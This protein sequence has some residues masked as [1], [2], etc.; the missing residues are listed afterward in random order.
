VASSSVKI[1]LVEDN[2]INQKV[3]C[4]QLKRLGYTTVAIAENGEEALEMLRLSEYDIVLMDCQ[5]PILDGYSAT[6]AIRARENGTRHLPVIAMTAHAMKGD[7]EK[8][9]A[10]G[11]DDYISKPVDLALLGATIQK[12]LALPNQG[13]AA[14]IGEIIV[15]PDLKVGDIQELPSPLN[16][17]EQLI[18]WH[19]LQEISDGDVEFQREILTVFVEDGRTTLAKLRQAIENGDIQEV[20]NLAHALKGASGNTGIP[21]IQETA[22][23]LER[24]VRDTGTLDEGMAI[25]ATLERLLSIL[26]ASIHSQLG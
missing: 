23:S 19:R 24:L 13:Q 15:K 1:L 21:P 14:V 9:L 6:K 18:D 2:A 10:A 11:M 20:K 7:R 8:C 12:W 5:M 16:N 4:N 22:A 26:A 17:Q 25:V 3:V